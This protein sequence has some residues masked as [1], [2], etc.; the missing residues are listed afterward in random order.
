MF[1]QTAKCE[2]ENGSPEKKKE[3]F[4]DLGSNLILNFG[5]LFVVMEEQREVSANRLAE[6][7]RYLTANSKN[8]QCIFFELFT[9]S[10]F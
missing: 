6:A 8:P 7:S 2:F 10:C 3:I 1:A 5:K 4:A 9:G